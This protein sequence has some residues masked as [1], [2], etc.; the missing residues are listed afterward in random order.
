M[1]PVEKLKILIEQRLNT[2]ELESEGTPCMSS[3]GTGWT[4][5]AFSRAG[6]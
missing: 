1:A 2:K 6:E 5:T 3:W 4:Y